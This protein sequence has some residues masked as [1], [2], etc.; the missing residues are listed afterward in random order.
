[1]S[2]QLEEEREEIELMRSVLDKERADM[3]KTMSIGARIN[4]D[5]LAKRVNTS[6]EEETRIKQSQ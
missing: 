5:K 1:M 6:H 2:D 3:V 4:Y